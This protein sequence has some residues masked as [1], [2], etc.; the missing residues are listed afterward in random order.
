MDRGWTQ[1]QLPSVKVWTYPRA[2]PEHA[3]YSWSSGNSPLY[4]YTESLSNTRI[5]YAGLVGYSQWL[6]YY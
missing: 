3:Q 4:P 6:F 5:F 2:T 1:T